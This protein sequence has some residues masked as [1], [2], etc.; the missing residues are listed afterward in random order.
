MDCDKCGICQQEIP[1]DE[2]LY[3]T[4]TEKGALGVCN[5]SR[6]RGDNLIIKTA[7]KVHRSCR[8]AYNNKKNIISYNK[9]KLS[10]DGESNVSK[11]MLRTDQGFDF[12]MDCLCCKNRI[13]EREK[14]DNKAYQVMSKNREFDLSILKVREECNDLWAMEVKGRIAFSNDLHSEDAMYHQVCSANFRTGK[15]I[16]QLYDDGPKSKQSAKRG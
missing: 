5:A 7:D 16:P 6:E 15:G 11:R 2:K 3:V 9:K 10:T 14:R 13:T 12:K 4:L 8:G 1:N